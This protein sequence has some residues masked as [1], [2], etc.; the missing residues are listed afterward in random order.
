[1]KWSRLLAPIIIVLTTLLIIRFNYLPGTWL[2]GWDTLHPEF[3]FQLNFGRLIW[4]VWRVDQ[5]LGALAAHSHMAELPR[6]F[7]LWLVSLVF[8]TDVLRY[9]YV[10]ACFILGPLG[11]YWFMERSV[12]AETK[13]LFARQSASLLAAFA[14]IFNF[15][16]VQ[17]FYVPF[18]MFPAQYAALG[19][20]F[21]LIT[22]YVKKKHQL[23]L[24]LFFF[25]AF[26]ST[27]MAYASLLWFAMAGGIG[28]YL[29]V[30][31]LQDRHRQTL[32]RCLLVV[33]AL[34]GA[35]AFWLFPNLYFVAT[36]TD[37]VQNARINRIFSEEAFLHN[38]SYGTLKDVALI[39]SFL[40]NW[41]VYDH[42]SEEFTQLLTGWREHA[43]KAAV[44]V[45]GYGIF[46][47]AVSGV[48]ISVAKKN[49]VLIALL[50]VGLMSLLMLINMN[51]PFEILFSYLRE[52]VG[53]FKEGLRNP[54]TKFSIIYMFVFAVYLGAFWAY[55]F[56]KL[57]RIPKIKLQPVVLLITLGMSGILVYIGLPMFSGL[58]ISPR[59]KAEI[60]QAYF[61]FQEWMQDKPSAA[62]V[63]LFPVHTMWGWDYNDW[64]YQGSG[65]IWF[66]IPQPVLVRDFDRWSEFNEGF[67]KQFNYAVYNQDVSLV[68]QVLDKHRVGYV[69]VDSSLINPAGNQQVLYLEEFADMV[70]ESDKL[71]RVAEFDFIS[72]YQFQATVPDSFVWAPEN[73]S[74][75]SATSPY[76]ALDPIYSNHRTYVSDPA[77]DRLV[78]PFAGLDGLSGDWVE[79][80]GDQAVITRPVEL[81][82]KPVQIV[83]PNYMATEKFVPVEVAVRSSSPTELTLRLQVYA[84]ELSSQGQVLHNAQIWQRFN[85]QVPDINQIKFL[86]IDDQVYDLTQVQLT[87][88][89]Q[90]VGNA[91]IFVNQQTP[92]SLY[93][94]EAEPIQSIQSGLE[95]NTPRLCAN[96]SIVAP[97]TIQEGEFELEVGTE[98]VC[99]GTE[100]PLGEN[101]LVQVE[102]EAESEDGVFPWFCVLD[103]ESGNCVNDNIP[104]EFSQGGFVGD[105]LYQFPLNADDYWFALVVQGQETGMQRSLVYRDVSVSTHPQLLT[106]SINFGA[107]FAFVSREVVLEPEIDISELQVTLPNIPIVE[108]NFSLSRGAARELNCDIYERGRVDKQH[109][110]SQIHYTAEDSGVSCDYFDYLQIPTN[111]GYIF[112]AVGNNRQGRSIKFYLYN[113]TTR[114]MD[115]EELLDPGLFDNSYVLL[116]RLNDRGYTVNLETRAF[117]KEASRN[118]LSQLDFWPIP[119][120][121]LQQVQVKLPGKTS[122]VN[123]LNIEEV[124][125]VNPIA[126]GAKISSPGVVALAYSDHPG[127][128]AYVLDHKPTTLD[129]IWGMLPGRQQLEKVRVNGWSNGWRVDA[130]VMPQGETAYVFMFF[131]PQYL[132]WLGAGVFAV[133]FVGLGLRLAL[134][135]L[136]NQPI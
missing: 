39:K 42:R 31:W 12:L 60:P 95:Q 75:I 80:Q 69:V 134:R 130:E 79:Y 131:W 68:E 62:R 41:N 74:Q 105:Y 88:Q 46:L 90:A 111:Q 40:F 33:I 94:R 92:V 11:V 65:L 98:S 72:V 37:V 100:F 48:V 124:V 123:S 104:D 99:L 102:F 112:R 20:L 61:D 22:D 54:F 91:L 55:V 59:L 7:I 116:P 44:I 57:S 43:V 24:L 8:E 45:F 19:W 1:M 87:S 117:G 107:N 97:I 49:R 109:G 4:G 129:Y 128:V 118:S 6:V 13:S 3:N 76:T 25:V 17:H 28:L 136:R 120:A 36:G 2:T 71:S 23:S 52:N 29:V 110:F 32:V 63:A 82:D 35:N 86:T 84:P 16:T 125:Q 85:F 121:W 67:Y 64:G 127:W 103:R 58:L 56:D 122:V 83:Y 26:V 10:F 89:F 78:Y 15:G 34:V 96:P 126:F 106:T 77:S 101:A 108:E 50:P 21:G 47:L 73:Y 51:P 113:R 132:Q 27:P 9:L 30:L 5:G 53:A 38:K 115:T 93:S 14:Y 119:Y 133:V 81:A 66:G 135:M 70:A 18:E 114:R